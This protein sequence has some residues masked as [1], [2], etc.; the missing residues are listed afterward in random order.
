MKIIASSFWNKN[1]HLFDGFQEVYL[2]GSALDKDDPEDIDLILIYGGVFT[3]ELK[4]VCSTLRIRVYSYFGIRAHLTILSV[5]EEVETQ[6]LK[7]VKFLK[8]K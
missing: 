6:M 3:E 5:S 7:Q 1:R 2:F 8:I 4:Q